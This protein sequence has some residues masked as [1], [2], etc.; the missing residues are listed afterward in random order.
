MHRLTPDQWQELSPHLDEILG[1]QDEERSIWL[2]TLR[3]QNPTLVEHLETLF[4]EHRAL[5]E[6]GFLETRRKFLAEMQEALAQ[7]D[8][9]ALKRLAHKVAGG[10]AMYGFAWAATHCRAME[11][12]ALLGD[13]ADLGRRLEAVRRHLGGVQISYRNAGNMEGE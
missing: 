4:A 11:R 13:A 8:R 6:E 5:V 10:F 9:P 3:A 7:D 1:M 12:D 2:S